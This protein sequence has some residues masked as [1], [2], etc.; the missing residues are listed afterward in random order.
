MS[1][2]CTAMGYSALSRRQEIIYVSIYFT[3]HFQANRHE[4]L[5]GNNTVSEQGVFTYLHRWLVVTE[6]FSPQELEAIVSNVTHITTINADHSNVR[7]L[8]IRIIEI[9]L[10]GIIIINRFHPIITLMVTY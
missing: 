5:V 2:Q 8:S 7:I 6:D 1:K 10:L 4:H 9:D 3:F